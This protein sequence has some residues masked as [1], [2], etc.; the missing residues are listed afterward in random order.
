MQVWRFGDVA[1]LDFTPSRAVRL[2][3]HTRESFTQSITATRCN[4]VMPTVTCVPLGNCQTERM[5]D[6]IEMGEIADRGAIA[7]SVRGC[8]FI[9]R[10]I[11]EFRTPRFGLIDPRPSP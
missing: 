11:I 1:D 5:A 2:L 8:P 9:A 7:V 4:V 10:N 6:I 3:S